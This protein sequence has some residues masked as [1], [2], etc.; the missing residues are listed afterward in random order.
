MC[1]TNDVWP[2]KMNIVATDEHVGEVERSIRTIKDATRCHVHI[3]LYKRYPRQM[4]NNCV[5]M[6][7]KCLNQLLNKKGVCTNMSPSSIVLG[8]CKPDCE[9]LKKLNFGDYVQIHQPN[10]IT[11]DNK[12]RTVGTI[13]LHPSGNLQ[14][15]WYF[16]S[17]SSGE[18]LHR[19]QWH[20]LPISTEVIHR[21]H[22]I[23]I[24]EGQPIIKGNF[25]FHNV[26]GHLN[27]M[28]DNDNDSNNY[29]IDH[30]NENKIDETRLTTYD[31][32]D[33]ELNDSDDVNT[34]QNSDTNND[35]RVKLVKS[36][37]EYYN[38][39][40]DNENIPE[41]DERNNIDL[42]ILHE[43]DDDIENYHNSDIVSVDGNEID[44]VD[45]INT[46]QIKVEQDINI[47]Q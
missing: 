12:A 31:N 8:T 21:V 2:I 4:V 7:L 46:K 9:E 18:R 14:E 36:E 42:D 33:S 11:N 22:E 45:E 28:T 27:D 43:D 29:T 23:A 41:T 16:M 5:G 39:I 20:V 32:T 13:A 40:E 38:N 26:K 25:E 6:V 1:I 37:M 3:L 24:K 17:L 19:Y 34:L 10:H 35:N 30:E 15:S 44:D 47:Y